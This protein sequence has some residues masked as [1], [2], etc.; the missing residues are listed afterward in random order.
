MQHHPIQTPERYRPFTEEERREIGRKLRQCL[1]PEYMANRPGPGGSKLTY[2]EGHRVIALAH[3]ILGFDGWS[4]AIISSQI[5]YARKEAVTDGIKRALRSFGN[6]LGNCVYD[7]ESLNRVKK[8]TAIKPIPL[9][10]E[11]LYRGAEYFPQDEI[12]RNVIAPPVQPISM[13][14]LAH[15]PPVPPAQNYDNEFDDLDDLFIPGD[16]ENIDPQLLRGPAPAPTSALQVPSKPSPRRAMTFSENSKITQLSK[17]F[18]NTPSPSFAV[19]KGGPLPHAVPL[20]GVGGSNGGA[21]SSSVTSNSSAARIPTSKPTFSAFPT[22]ISQHPPRDLTGNTSGN[23]ATETPKSAGSTSGI[24]KLE[25][26]KA[27]GHFQRHQNSNQQQSNQQ[28]TNETSNASINTNHINHN[29][30]INNTNSISN[31]NGVDSNN[32]IN[33]S[34]TRTHAQSKPLAVIQSISGGGQASNLNNGRGSRE[35]GRRLLIP[36]H[37]L[38][39]DPF[40]SNP[41]DADQANRGPAQQDHSL[42]PTFKPASET[43]RQHLSNNNNAASIN[44]NSTNKPEN[45]NGVKRSYTTASFSN[46]PYK[47]NQTT[48]FRSPLKP[49]NK[50]NQPPPAQGS[51]GSKNIA[52]TSG[53]KNW[54]VQ[55]IQ[56][57]QQP[58]QPNSGGS[59]GRTTNNF[60]RPPPSP[61]FNSNIP[62]AS[63]SAKRIRTDL[64]ANAD[65]DV[66][67]SPEAQENLGLQLGKSLGPSSVAAL[68]K[69]QESKPVTG[70]KATAVKT[71]SKAANDASKKEKQDRKPA[72]LG[73]SKVQETIALAKASSNPS[74]RANPS[75][76]AAKPP[77]VPVAEK[78]L[79]PTSRATRGRAAQTS[80]TEEK[81]P[82]LASTKSTRSTRS[83]ADTVPAEPAKEQVLEQKRPRQDSSEERGVRSSMDS[84]MVDAP[85]GTEAETADVK[86]PDAAENDAKPRRR[87]PRTVNKSQASSRPA[88]TKAKTLKAEVVETED[89]ADDE[90]DDDNDVEEENDMGDIAPP[91][92]GSAFIMPVD[93]PPEATTP[94]KRRGRGAAAKLREVRPEIPSSSPMPRKAE[95][96]ASTPPSS[97]ASPMGSPS[98]VPAKL[99][100][101]ATILSGLSGLS[102]KRADI[103]MNLLARLSAGTMTTFVPKPAEVVAPAPV[104]PVTAP[105]PR[106]PLPVE[107]GLP[108]IYMVGNLD[109][110]GFPIGEDIFELKCFT[111]VDDLPLKPRCVAA[112]SQHVLVVSEDGKTV[113]SFGSND[114]DALGR[115]CDDSRE[116]QMPHA[117]EGLEGLEIKKVSCCDSLSVFLTTTGKVYSC[118]SFKNMDGENHFTQD[119]ESQDIP[120]LVEGF[121]EPVTDIA[122][123]ANFVLALGH[124]Q[125]TRTQVNTWK[126]Y[127][128][129]VT[130]KLDGAKAKTVIFKSVFAGPHT[131]F[132]IDTNGMVY[133]FGSNNWGQL[134]VGD[135]LP[136]HPL[137]TLIK[138][139]AGSEALSP[140]RSIASG[141]FHTIFLMEDGTM[142]ASGRNDELQ[143]GQGQKGLATGERLSSVPVPIP[144]EVGDGEE[145]PNIVEISCGF[146]HNVA[147]DEKGGVWTWGWGEGFM[148]GHANSKSVATPTKCDW[149][150]RA[151]EVLEGKACRMEGLRV[152]MATAGA[153]FTLVVAEN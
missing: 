46:V 69:A 22:P 19:H 38:P 138:G 50:E 59:K 96:V 31:N 152:T 118:G 68:G 146:D 21:P 58:Q 128:L 73:E 16:I 9:T 90:M 47:P 145:L 137:P 106:Q 17:D 97:E 74:T 129:G 102:M 89:T 117:V 24:A 5:D 88:R 28:T 104:V 6:A 108:G 94:V 44:S 135:T 34:S 71:T 132:A 124:E 45:S 110:V 40:A 48:P 29:M 76:S 30:N 18:L 99:I 109:N 41:L 116:E 49:K 122:S 32:S 8:I 62:V 114:D 100:S 79:K 75:Q 121:S 27:P 10:R 80:A 153:N 113:F 57:D 149:V 93:S 15:A 66:T 112:G 86:E 133:G 144:F 92:L 134:G 37:P 85:Q 95:S 70:K 140:V 123:G 142:H 43:F 4:H 35:E 1:G 83:K 60:V 136:V 51:S 78:E 55:P 77:M 107:K 61:S 103:D 125:R 84:E 111:R 3:E 82:A 25:Q 56:Q 151:S 63:P 11:S 42:A 54:K 143:L 147:V 13:P 14:P 119:V 2:V 53:N 87:R 26:F 105:K 20:N 130:S 64:A 141:N 36:T 126:P 120:V 33:N 131:A 91:S 127:K 39:P 52:S 67:A 139:G 12:V 7:K 148:L 150:A 23:N 98:K 65:S 72:A 101:T 115:N 81:E